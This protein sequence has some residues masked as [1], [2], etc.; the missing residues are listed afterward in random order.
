MTY[1]DS[2]MAKG[3][4]FYDMASVKAVDA[5]TTAKTSAMPYFDSLDKKYK[6]RAMYESY[7]VEDVYASLKVF[8]TETWEQ[9]EALLQ[10]AME[11]E[12]VKEGLTRV[13]SFG[14]VAQVRYHEML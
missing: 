3:N 11:N 14:D 9:L 8:I 1:R 13:K 6:L 12:R 4:E 2:A 10:G 5:Y 7:K